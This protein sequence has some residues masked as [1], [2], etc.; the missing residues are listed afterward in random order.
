MMK[1]YGGSLSYNDIMKMNIRQFGMFQRAMVYM[2]KMQT[3]EGRKEIE[4]EEAILHEKYF[5]EV[6]DLSD[7]MNNFQK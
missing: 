6:V 4:Y 1:F 2:N 3:E 7:F 5:G